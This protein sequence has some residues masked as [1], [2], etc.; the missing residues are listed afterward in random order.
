ML[1]KGHAHKRSSAFPCQCHS[2]DSHRNAIAKA[3]VIAP[4]PANSRSS[5]P[6]T[7]HTPAH[8]RTRAPSPR[9]PRLLRISRIQPTSLRIQVQHIRKAH[10]ADKTAG[11][12]PPCE[13]EG[14]RRDAG[15]MM[16]RSRGEVWGVVSTAWWRW[17][18]DGGSGN[19]LRCW[20]VDDW[21]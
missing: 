8:T 3:I 16:G 20:G 14:S 18:R 6:Q 12:D 11:L 21:W 19:R 17:R 7:L 4:S 15:V 2:T 5:Q 9:F 10:D 1:K 13:R